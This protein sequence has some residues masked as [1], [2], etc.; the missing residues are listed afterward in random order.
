MMSSGKEES[1]PSP[2]FLLFIYSIEYLL[3]AVKFQVLFRMVII[4]RKLN[5]IILIIMINTRRWWRAHK[6]LDAG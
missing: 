1:V 5:V 3:S 2:N 6:V 4:F